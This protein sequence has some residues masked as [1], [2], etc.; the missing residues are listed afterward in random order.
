MLVV[1]AAALPLAAADEENTDTGM[2]AKSFAGLKFRS[3]GPAL[4]SGRIAD[5]AIHPTDPST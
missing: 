3:I 5:I 4:M 2:T 1:F